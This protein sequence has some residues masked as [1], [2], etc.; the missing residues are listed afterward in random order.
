M[1]AASPLI[2]GRLLNFLEKGSVAVL[3][4]HLQEIQGALFSLIELAEEVAQVAQGHLIPWIC[5]PR[6]R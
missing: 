3:V 1:Q 5:R 4:L 6:Q 2:P